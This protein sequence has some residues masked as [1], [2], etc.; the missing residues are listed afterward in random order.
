MF[1]MYI[2]KVDWDVACVSE[3]CCKCF[4]DMLQASIQNVSTVS[5]F[6]L[7]VAYVAVVIHICCKHLL[8]MFHMFQT[9]VTSVLSEC[10][11]CCKPILQMFHLC[12]DACCKSA[13]CCNINRHRKRAHAACARKRSGRGWSPAACA[14]AGTGTQHHVYA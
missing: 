14:S 1:Y 12:L 8:K 7:D 6:Y 10:C 11:I 2:A 5:V 13:S 4:R 3:V 9:Y